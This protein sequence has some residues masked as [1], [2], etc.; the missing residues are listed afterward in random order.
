MARQLVAMVV[1]L[2]IAT[3]L[4]GLAERRWPA[5][6][7]RSF[8]QRKGQRTDLAYWFVNPLLTRVAL[9][10]ALVATVVPLAVVLGA[11]LRGDAIEAW[12]AARRTFVSV[13]PA[14][15]QGLEIVIL[16]D[17]IGYWTHRLFHGRRLWRFHAVHHATRDLDWLSSTRVHPVNE[18]LTRVAAIVPLFVLGFRGDVLVKLTPVFG[19]YALA[20]HANVPWTLGPFRYVLASPAFHRWHHSAEE[21]GQGRNFAAMFPVWDL[22][23]GTFYLPVG[24]QPKVF[25]VSDTVP[26]GILAQL[27]WPFRWR[28]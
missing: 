10:A 4:L 17:F 20:I 12:I 24:E 7:G 19:L 11:P 1:A 9:K 25:G 5:L 26:E 14:W 13:Q 16:A 2:V 21:R 8:W 6:P 27:A 23:F 28:G 22:I 15:L 3:A 18:V